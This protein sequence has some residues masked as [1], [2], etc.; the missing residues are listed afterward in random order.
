MPNWVLRQIDGKEYRLT[1]AQ[2]DLINRAIEEG[3]K[4]VHLG[5]LVIN[6]NYVERYWKVKGPEPLP[7]RDEIKMSPEK[8]AENLRRLAEIVGRFKGDKDAS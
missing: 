1:A 8:T 6:V 7:E 2:I 5:K 3:K 4:F